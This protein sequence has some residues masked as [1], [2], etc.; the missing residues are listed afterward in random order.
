VDVA[1]EM[2]VKWTKGD[3]SAI[4]PDL[5]SAVFGIAIKNGGQHEVHLPILN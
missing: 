1:K 3:K 2:F 5:R 4:H